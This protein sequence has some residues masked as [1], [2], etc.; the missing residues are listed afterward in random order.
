MKHSLLALLLILSLAGCSG[1]QVQNPNS[2]PCTIYQDFGATPENS[3]IAKKIA[4]PC[5]AQRVL[6]TAAKLPAVWAGPDYFSKFGSWANQVQMM[7]SSGITYETLQLQIIKRVAE[8]NAEVGMALL[9]ASDSLLVFQGEVALVNDM[10]KRLLLAS[11]NDL[12]VQVA[13]MG[14]AYGGAK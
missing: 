8:Y 14:L 6:V 13:N 11:L 2:I 5:A 10:D 1:L 9:I 12:R 3:L 4:N 7:I